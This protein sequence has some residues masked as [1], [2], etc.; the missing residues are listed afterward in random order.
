MINLNSVTKVK[1]GKTFYVLP[2]CVMTDRVYY[3]MD[4]LMDIRD[5]TARA[6]A[7]QK[8]RESVMM[9]KS[10]AIVTRKQKGNKRYFLGV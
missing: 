5:F 10:G 3:A 2:G 8:A 4:V 7:A 6:V 9:T 1:K